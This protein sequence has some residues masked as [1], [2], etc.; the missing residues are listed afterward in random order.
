[1]ILERRLIRVVIIV[2]VAVVFLLLFLSGLYQLLMAVWD[3]REGTNRDSFLKRGMLGVG[4]MLV[5]FFV[6]FFL[7]IM[8]SIPV[9]FVQHTTP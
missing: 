3:L 6:P 2:L 9:Q 8:A 1:M 5:A 7:M 4:L